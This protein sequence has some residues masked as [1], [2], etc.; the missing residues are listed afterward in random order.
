MKVSQSLRIK[1]MLLTTTISFIVFM[2]FSF[3][4]IYLIGVY[5]KEQEAEIAKRS[6]S[7]ISVIMATKNI[8]ELK[9][10]D[11]SRSLSS[12]D[13]FVYFNR[14]GEQLFSISGQSAEKVDIAFNPTTKIISKDEVHQGK[15][16]IVMY[17]PLNNANFHGYVVLVHSLKN[18]DDVIEFLIIISSFSSL[19]ALFLT[20]MLSYVFSGQITKP[21]RMIAE[22]MKRIK[23]DG[24]QN[25]LAF[26]TQY[27]E[28]NDLIETFNEMM[29]Q[30]EQSFDQQKQF[31]EDASH[32]LRTPL[33]I[34]N[35][36]LNLIK[37]W[38]KN[39]PEVLEESLSI[40]IEEMTRINKLVE[41]LLILSKDL[42]LVESSPQEVIDI[43]EEIKSRINAFSQLKSEYTFDF[44]S[45]EKTIRLTINRF[46]FEQ[47]LTIFLDNAIKY[48]EKNKRIIVRTTKKNKFAQIEIIDYGIGIPEEDLL[49]IFDRFYRVDK[50]RARSKGGNG[51][52]L[53]IAKKLI[54][55]YSGT[56]SIE[57]ELHVYTKVK[58][59]L[60]IRS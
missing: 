8:A 32:E 37:R 5:Q 25:K 43:N 36:H 38:G 50:S 40:S 49:N 22:Q 53:S 15:N 9:I 44:H 13:T 60:P 48:D 55:T 19:T 51:L 42:S 20:A 26:S 34:I 28:T 54:E 56:V 2:L 7:D 16:Y 29:T 31:V 59:Q 27:H 52:G 24:F 1:W 23:R 10:D 21:I 39:K 46:H 33:Q 45:S 41:E 3:L 18:H 4:I 58:I 11:L 35:G 6:L 12:S 17:S 47:I 14:Q 57:S 30:L